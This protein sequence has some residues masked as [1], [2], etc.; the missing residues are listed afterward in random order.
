MRS[1][2]IE[3]VSDSSADEAD[4]FLLDGQQ[5]LTSLYQSL[6]HKGPVTTQD[7]RGQSVE[8]WYYIDM[9]GAMNPEADRDDAIISVPYDR[10]ATSDFGRETIR[11]L[12]TRE[13]EYKHHMMPT[14]LLLTR[15]AAWERGYIDHWREAGNHPV[16]DAGEFLDGFLESVKDAFEKYQVPV[17]TL[18]KET[19]KEAVCQVFQKVNQGGIPLGT[20]ELV[21]A[22]FAAEVEDFSLRDDWRDRKSRL[23]RYAALQNISGDQFPTGG[24]PA[25]DPGKPQESRRGRGCSD[26]AHQLQKGSDAGVEPL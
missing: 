2:L 6:K 24:I 7:S 22:A 11:D 14:E 15:G 16:G 25:G 13:L 23:N 21:T 5:R 1:R 18:D 9:L 3:G 26:A 17:I 10:V 20:F 8:R 19:P 12:S 4:A